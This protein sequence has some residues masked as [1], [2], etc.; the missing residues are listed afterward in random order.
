MRALTGGLEMCAKPHFGF[1]IDVH[2]LEC[3]RYLGHQ[4]LNSL[5]QIT[6]IEVDRSRAPIVVKDLDP[7][8]HWLVGVVKLAEG[9]TLQLN[10][11]DIVQGI[12]H[13]V[14]KVAECFGDTVFVHTQ[15]DH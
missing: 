5:S 10:L 14:W 8:T 15:S 13:L 12:A 4:V 7:E 1:G 2:S 9:Q 6:W 11:A 3:L